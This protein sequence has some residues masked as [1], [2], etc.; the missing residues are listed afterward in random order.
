MGHDKVLARCICGK[1]K[2]FYKSNITPS[3]NKRHTRSCGCKQKEIASIKNTKHGLSTDKFHKRWSSM[4]D[5]MSPKYKD[6]KSYIGLSVCDEWK[7]FEKFRDD[8][9]KSYLIHLKKYGE[10]NTTLDRINVYKG[11]SKENCRWATTL[12]QSLNKK[13]TIKVIYKGKEV[14]LLLLCIKLN[15]DYNR[16]YRRIRSGKTIESALNLSLWQR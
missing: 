7:S 8:M 1:E 15:K 4:F 2:Q 11:Y 6:A 12:T 14:P 5:R 16:V 10:K 13:N 3:E 9:Y